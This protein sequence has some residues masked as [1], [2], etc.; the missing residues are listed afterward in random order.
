MQFD[1]V[2]FQ[3]RIHIGIGE[4]RVVLAVEVRE[5]AAIARHGR[6]EHAHATV[7]TVR[8]TGTERA[9]FENAKL[10]EDKQRM[11]AGAGEVAVPDAHLPF[12]ITASRHPE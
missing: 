9:A 4:S 3:I 7:S 12:A 6:P 1:P 11:I 10:V 5:L 8:V 2:G